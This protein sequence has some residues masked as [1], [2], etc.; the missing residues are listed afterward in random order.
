MSS[1]ELYFDGKNKTLSEPRWQH[2]RVDNVAVAVPNEEGQEPEEPL[3]DVEEQRSD[4]PLP[5]VGR[6]K[7]EQDVVGDVEQVGEVEDLRKRGHCMRQ[8]L[9]F[10][11]M[12]PSNLVLY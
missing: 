6:V 4:G 2:V 12:V 3:Q 1:I 11:T 7:D 10:M 5:E 9:L 8:M